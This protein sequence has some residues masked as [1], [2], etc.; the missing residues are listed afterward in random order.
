MMP[1]L[2][3]RAQ[4]DVRILILLQDVYFKA[5]DPFVVDLID[6]RREKVIDRDACGSQVLRKFFQQ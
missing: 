5:I 1:H 3:V 6:M 2:F 4:A